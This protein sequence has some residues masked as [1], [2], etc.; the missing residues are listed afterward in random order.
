MEEQSLTHVP[1]SIAECLRSSW[2]R[3]FSSLSE[4]V[5]FCCRKWVDR[6]SERH[7]RCV[8]FVLKLVFICKQL[9]NIQM[10]ISSSWSASVS[11][12]KEAY[13]IKRWHYSGLTNLPKYYVRDSKPQT[14]LRIAKW[15]AH[16]FIVNVCFRVYVCVAD[17]DVRLVDGNSMPACRL[18]V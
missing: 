16:V 13:L 11:K 17:L 4:F 15:L 9:I 12:K 8:M 6:F 1:W 18:R 3:A 5:L 7:R 10:R 2:I 14:L